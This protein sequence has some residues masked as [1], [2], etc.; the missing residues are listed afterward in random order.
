MLKTIRVRLTLWYVALLA[1]ILTVFSGA[2]YFT[3]AHSLDQQVNDALRVN[4]EQAAGAVNIG[5]GQVSFQSGENDT[6]DAISVRERGYLV[7]L[8]DVSGV[9]V[10]ANAHFAA[11]PVEQSA[12]AAAR[13]GQTSLDT[14][15]VN[16]QSFRTLTRPIVENGQFYGSLQLAHSLDEVAATLRELLLILAISVPLTLI[17]ASGGGF[18]FAQRALAPMDHITRAAQRISAQDLS[19]RL[20]LNLPDDEVGRLARTFDRMLAR[21]DDA[22]QR[23]RQFT[24]D[25]SHELRTPLTVMRGEI[26]VTLNR[27]RSAMEY[28]RALEALGSDVDRLTRLAEDLLTLARVDAGR[29]TVRCEELN[30]ECLLSAVAEQLRPLAESKHVALNVQSDG[31]AT[32]W[33]DEDKLLRALFNLVDNALKFTSTGGRVELS[34]TR[35]GDRVALAVADNGAGI[36]AE[37]LPHIFERFYRAD[38]AHSTRVGGAGLGLAIARSLVTALGGTMTVES[39]V[40][41]VA[42]HGLRDEN[43]PMLPSG[44]KFVI[45]LPCEAKS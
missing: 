40:G 35:E 34:A 38:G 42:T 29:L 44:T 28:R 13:R 15:F 7:R 11:V 36:S 32:V 39:V 31:A 2:L 20:S 33:A 12:L 41:G 26:D 17:L 23:E 9:T 25:A 45:R 37:H 16:G 22:F 19:Q 21:L 18:W 8:V 27:S 4:A 14:L 6:S 3:L 1:L 10:D 43:A 5:Q 24:A 30:A